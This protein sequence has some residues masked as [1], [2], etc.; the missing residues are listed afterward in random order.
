MA[1]KHPDLESQE[2]TLRRTAA[3]LKSAQEDL[4]YAQDVFVDAAH[5]ALQLATEKQGRTTGLHLPPLRDAMCEKANAAQ[6]KW[7]RNPVR[8]L[9]SGPWEQVEFCRFLSSKG[10]VIAAPGSDVGTLVLGSHSFDEEELK[11]LLL[12]LE[13]RTPIFTQELL[14]CGLIRQL[15]PYEP[16]HQQSIAMLASHPAVALILQS[17]RTWPAPPDTPEDEL[18]D[19]VAEPSASQANGDGWEVDAPFDCYVASGE[20]SPLQEFGYSVDSNEL[21]DWS[22]HGILERVFGAA[23]L[24]GLTYEE[25]QHWGTGGSAVRLQ[26]IRS[27][28]ASLAG[29][30]DHQTQGAREKLSGDLEWLRARYYRPAMGFEWPENTSRATP[31]RVLNAALTRSIKPD[32]VLAAVIGPEPASRNEIVAKLWAYIREHQLQDSKNKK[33]IN[34]DDKLRPLFGKDQI[35]MYQLAGVISRH[36]A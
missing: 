3:S 6:C 15:P 7:A 33:M 21:D 22:R 18:N 23:A 26:A 20:S 35:S 36:V 31:K 2:L 13:D 4:E 28:L 34:A 1:T 27:F 30:P 9:G 16:L 10:F 19:V 14:V 24:P 12:S 29:L 5:H 17:G 25:Q 11:D 32:L 8:V